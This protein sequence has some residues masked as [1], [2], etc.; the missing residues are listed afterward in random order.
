MTSEQFNGIKSGKHNLPPAEL[1][2]TKSYDFM[3]KEDRSYLI[4]PLLELALVQE[5]K[6]M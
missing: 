2:I 4:R 5:V 6:N 1:I 3:K